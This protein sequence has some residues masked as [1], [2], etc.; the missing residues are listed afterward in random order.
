LRLLRSF[1]SGAQLDALRDGP[2]DKHGSGSRIL[3]A[4]AQ[5]NEAELARL[6]EFGKD[7]QDPSGSS[8]RGLTAQEIT[9][10]MDA[11]FA[12]AKGKR[13][14]IDRQL[15]KGEWPVL[16]RIMGKGEGDERYLSGR[17]SGRFS[18]S[19]NCLSGL[20]RACSRSR[21]PQ[22]TADPFARFA[23]SCSGRP[24]SP[25]RQFS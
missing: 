5:V 6:A 16:L 15:M 20:S 7:R 13:R 25:A 12:R 2:L 3:D 17:K 9:A 24:H 4:T 18:S 14:W 11:N 21:Y 10:Y 8:E 22:G 19:G 1:W 23:N